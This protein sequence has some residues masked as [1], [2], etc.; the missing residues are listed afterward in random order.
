MSIDL[1]FIQFKVDCSK[2]TY[3]RSLAYDYGV[4][5]KSG[6]HLSKL[7]RESIG[8]YHLSS[9]FKIEEFQKSIL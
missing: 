4:Q 1:P 6:S 8:D 3:I 7:R 2:G 5:L 9:A